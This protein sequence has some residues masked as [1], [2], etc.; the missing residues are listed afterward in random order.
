LS[1]PG[2][3]AKAAA[4][5]CLWLAL[6]TAFLAPFAYFWHR[7]PW[8]DYLTANVLLLLVCSTGLLLCMN[9]LV[10]RLGEFFQDET[11]AVT[12]RVSRWVCWLLVVFPG[13]AILSGLGVGCWYQQLPFFDALGNL[14]GRLGPWA[15][16]MALAPACLTAALLWT[17]KAVG[18]AQIGELGKPTAMPSEQQDRDR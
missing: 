15:K 1:T 10:W 8:R 18:L 12:A 4:Q 2:A 6:V 7:A 14:L 5:R 17:L 13:V 9:R 3:R 16:T 11:L